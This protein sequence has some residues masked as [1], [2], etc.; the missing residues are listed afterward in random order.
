MVA[1]SP[2]PGRGSVQDSRWRSGAGRL[3]S[4]APQ[5]SLG[6][7]SRGTPTSVSPVGRADLLEM[8]RSSL[9]A[10]ESVLVVGPAGI[11]KSTV[12]AALADASGAG[13]P[14]SGAP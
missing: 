5:A 12:L 8:A 6:V 14:G 13:E 4:V 10:G 7:P 1:L 11:G 3:P 2:Q 9:D